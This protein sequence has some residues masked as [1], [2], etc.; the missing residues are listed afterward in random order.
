MQQPRP[1]MRANFQHRRTL[2]SGHDLDPGWRHPP[3]ADRIV[4]L[5]TGQP[6]RDVELPVHCAAQVLA[7]RLAVGRGAELGN[8][9]P[10]VDRDSPSV[11]AT[12]DRTESRCSASTPATLASSPIRGQRR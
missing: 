1:V 9:Q 6:I 5:P 4:R 10:G 3:G 2:A 11:R 12:A 8:R 7:Q